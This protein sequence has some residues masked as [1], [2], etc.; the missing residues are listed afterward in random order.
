MPDLITSTTCQEA[1]AYIKSLIPKDFVPRIGIASAT[2]LNFI[3]ELGIQDP[4]EVP[5]LQIPGFIDTATS[6]KAQG[7]LVFGVF[8][9]TPV[10]VMAG[11]CKYYEG[12]TLRQVTLPIRAMKLLGITTLIVTNA[13]ASINPEF[14]VGD[15]GVVEDHISFPS[16]SGLNP[17]VGPNYSNM[18][19]RFLS[20]SEAYSFKLRKLA[21]HM[22]L[23]SPELLKRKVE[24]K[25]AIYCYTVGPSFETRA[26]CAAIRTLGGDVVG[27]STIPE[28]Q[29]ARH[30]NLQVLCLTIVT[31][32]A[33]GYAR[34]SAKEA[35]IAELEGVSSPLPGD[36]EDFLLADGGASNRLGLSRH[37]DLVTLIKRIVDA[38]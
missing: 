5:F 14:K 36:D 29:V 2:G 11:S 24:L 17:L 6:T 38:L 32:V 35:A 15:I 21:F 26:E 20:M 1:V 25:D 4:I 22:W 18:G 33:H 8:Q 34:K 12:Y 9:D 37:A 28:V 30:C 3:S 27:S 23:T 13:S 31:T 19:P 16:I 7:K 10:V